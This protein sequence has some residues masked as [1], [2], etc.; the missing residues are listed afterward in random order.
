MKLM[1]HVAVPRISPLP[2]S[3]LLMLM[4]LPLGL[5]QL[6]WWASH[7]VKRCVGMPFHSVT[8]F[9]MSKINPWLTENNAVWDKDMS[10]WPEGWS[11]AEFEKFSSNHF[12]Y[13]WNWWSSCWSFFT[14]AQSLFPVSLCML[15]E[16]GVYC[17]YRAS[18]LRFWYFS[19]LLGEIDNFE[20]G[21]FFLW[22]N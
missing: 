19:L 2:L 17:Y 10:G 9:L 16:L 13:N 8:A 5:P 20:N 3:S 22:C 4:L 12:R 15:N 14:L 1:S 11:D 21:Q 18:W 6:C 7:K